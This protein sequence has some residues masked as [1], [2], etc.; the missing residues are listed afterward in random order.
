M[1]AVW[2]EQSRLN[3]DALRPLGRPGHHVRIQTPRE[4]GQS[5]AVL[6][7]S[8]ARS[9]S[10]TRRPGGDRYRSYVRDSICF[11]LAETQSV[12]ICGKMCRDLRAGLGVWAP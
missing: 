10:A 7:T 3:R 11:H 1:N 6:I 12:K 5:R 2:T 9:V 4:P 8:E